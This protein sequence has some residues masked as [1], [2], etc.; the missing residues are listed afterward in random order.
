MICIIIVN[1][2][3]VHGIRTY[4]VIHVD[5]VGEAGSHRNLEASQALSLEAPAFREG[6][7]R[8]ATGLGGV[9]RLTRMPRRCAFPFQFNRGAAFAGTWLSLLLTSYRSSP[10]HMDMEKPLEEDLLPDLESRLSTS[11]SKSDM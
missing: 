1:T 4:S 2:Y 11:P 6:R 7:A 8:V 5:I 9:A 10:S 3:F